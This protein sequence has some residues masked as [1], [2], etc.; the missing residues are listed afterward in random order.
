MCHIQLGRKSFVMVKR[1]TFP[2]MLRDL[3]E[4]KPKR[5]SLS[6]TVVTSA[7]SD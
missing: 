6:N 3:N 5:Y 1:K 4:A 7:I 2:E